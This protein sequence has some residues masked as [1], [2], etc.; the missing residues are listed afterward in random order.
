MND[1]VGIGGLLGDI[2]RIGACR[3]GRRAHRL[4]GG[5]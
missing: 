5:Q 1:T 3:Q 2:R 4:S